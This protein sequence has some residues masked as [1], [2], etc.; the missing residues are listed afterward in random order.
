MYGTNEISFLLFIRFSNL[1]V[2]VMTLKGLTKVTRFTVNFTADDW[3]LYNV[4]GRDAA[5]AEI[6]SVLAQ[7]LNRGELTRGEVEAEMM[8]VLYR[9]AELG[10]ADSEPTNFLMRVLDEAFR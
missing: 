1:L 9:F 5:A 8:S 10:A 3:D 6:N 4:Q 2:H 7:L